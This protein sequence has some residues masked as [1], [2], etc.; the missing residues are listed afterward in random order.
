MPT[1]Y[2]VTLGDGSLDPGDSIGGGAVSFTADGGYPSGLG[3]GQ[4]TWTGEAGGT[5]YTNEVEPGVYWLADNGDVYFVP[6]RGTVDFITSA[7]ATTA[8]TYEASGDGTVTGTSGDDTIDSSYTDDDGDVVDGGD[9][10]GA[11]GHEDEINAGAG[12][13]SVEA[14]QEN[15]TVYGGSGND[16]I[17]G[18]SGDDSLEGGDGSDLFIFEDGFGNDTVIGG[19]GGTDSDTIDLSAL[20]TAVTVTYT[21][22][23][24]GTITDGTNT[25]TISQIENITATEFADYIDA[26][27]ST[28][29]LHITAG[30]GDDTIGG[31]TGDDEV[32]GGNGVDRFYGFGGNDTFYGG[33]GSD[34][35]YMHG[36]DG[37]LTYHA[38]ED[39]DG[40][41]TDILD[42]W[43][44]TNSGM[45]VTF[46]G[47]EAGTFV[48]TDGLVTG[49]FTGVEAISATQLNDTID[50]SASSTRIALQAH[51]GDDSLVGSS[52]ADVLH[53]GV[54]TDTIEGGAGDD[55]I[56]GGEGD[57]SLTGGDGA[58]QFVLADNSGS[59][60]VTDFD[61]TDSGDGTTIDQLDVSDLTD[62]DGNSVNVWDVVVTDTNGDGTGDAILTFPNGESVT[63]TGVAPSQVNSAP[64]LNAMGIPC[65]TAGTQIATP[66]GEIA[67]E[68][69]RAGDLVT[70]LEHGPKP[71]R[72][73]ASSDLGDGIAPLPKNMIPV[74]I[75]PETMGNRLPLLVSPQHCILM[76]DEKE[77]RNIYVRAKH[78]A[79][80]TRLASYASGRKRVT[81]VHVLLDQHATLV[82]NDIPSESFYPGTMALEMLSAYNRVKLH[83]LVPGLT[84][85]PVEDVYGPRA[86]A[87][88]KRSDLRKMTSAGKLACFRADLMRA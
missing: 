3:A 69:L 41:D 2:L 71:V 10:A 46:S 25:V 11:S 45:T 55:T 27:A 22:D 4:W 67:V 34:R 19:E 9:G 81:Y 47:D 18:G 54:G 37:H 66:T 15:D 32:Y 6:D 76:T 44:Y 39:A 12:N 5:P 70:T 50:A 59:D 8:P 74:R 13:D 36:A 61:L 51:D 23:E 63:L 20:A 38:G 31:S 79:E 68:S 72:W 52:G 82:S 43:H 65:F 86:A 83:A 29:D 78:L 48:T 75:K 73:I 87:V 56:T 57:D 7:S 80:E 28:I 21:G 64:E 33:D 62:A 1:G 30:G 77:V 24:A 88:L 58:D 40:F 49:E 17:D 16:T 42:L 60:V 35:I 14:G 53:G 85:M 84:F 26:S